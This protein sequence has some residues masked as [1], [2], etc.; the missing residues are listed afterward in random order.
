[1]WKMWKILFKKQKILKVI[2]QNKQIK[3]KAVG[4]F[5][6]SVLNKKNYN[7]QSVL[8]NCNENSKKNFKLVCLFIIFVVVIY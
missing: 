1:M 8:H 4:D 7:F 2:I 3:I 5:W 6:I